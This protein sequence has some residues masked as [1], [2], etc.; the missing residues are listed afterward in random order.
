MIDNHKP[1]PI[2]TAVCSTVMGLFALAGR[3]VPS[4]RLFRHL[5]DWEFKT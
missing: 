1:P 4:D 5:P 2:L 3:S